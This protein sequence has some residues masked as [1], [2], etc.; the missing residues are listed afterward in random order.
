M[1]NKILDVYVT[2]SLLNKDPSILIN[3]NYNKST[4]STIDNSARDTTVDYINSTRGLFPHNTVISNNENY[5]ITG[6]EAPYGHI[7]DSIEKIADMIP[8]CP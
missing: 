5:K 3:I 2:S 1:N 8:A 4:N 7:K 6:I